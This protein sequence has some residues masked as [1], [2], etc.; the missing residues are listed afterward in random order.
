MNP[1][2]SKEP[3]VNLPPFHG[4]EYVKEY[5]EWEMKVVKIFEFHQVDEIKR[6]SMTSLSFQKNTM[7]WWKRKM[8]FQLG[9]NLKY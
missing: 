4:R 8:M 2:F 6:L 7:S 5:L 1:T 9:E 3:K